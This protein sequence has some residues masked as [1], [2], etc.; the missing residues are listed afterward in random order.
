MQREV[1]LMNHAARLQE[2]L[3]ESQDDGEGTASAL[4][5]GFFWVSAGT[6]ENNGVEVNVYPAFLKPFVMNQISQ[7]HLSPFSNET[8]FVGTENDFS[9][10]SLPI[11]RWL[12]AGLNL[13]GKYNNS[14]TNQLDDLQNITSFDELVFGLLRKIFNRVLNLR[15]DTVV[16]LLDSP[17]LNNYFASV[18][19]LLSQNRKIESFEKFLSTDL[20]TQIKFVLKQFLNW[21]CEENIHTRLGFWCSHETDLHGLVQASRSVFSGRNHCENLNFRL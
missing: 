11:R 8:F 20:N 7:G 9:E 18:M 15:A 19:Q 12:L 4:G 10:G 2:F 13:P 14:G 5:I 3:E 6:A 21:T 17:L 1:F 16:F